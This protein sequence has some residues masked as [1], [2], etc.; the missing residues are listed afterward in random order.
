MN[1]AVIKTRRFW[2]VAIFIAGILGVFIVHVLRG[3]HPQNYGAKLLLDSLPNFIC[4]VCVP[5]AAMCWRE[6]FGKH[7]LIGIVPGLAGAAIA[8]IILISWELVQ[9]TRPGMVFDKNDIIATLLG[10]LIWVIT[11]SRLDKSLPVA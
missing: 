7:S 6:Q 8:Q 9:R 5:A 2:L 10:G 3:Q 11:W 4:G 1:A